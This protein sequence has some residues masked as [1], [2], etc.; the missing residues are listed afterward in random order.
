MQTNCPTSGIAVN[1]IYNIKL[2][3]LSYNDLLYTRIAAVSIHDTLD[4]NNA[5]VLF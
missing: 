1:W 4:R 5:A 2:Q 3:P